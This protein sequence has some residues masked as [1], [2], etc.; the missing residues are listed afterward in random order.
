M[1]IADLRRVLAAVALL[2]AALALWFASSAHAGIDCDLNP[3]ARICN[4]DGD[5]GGDPGGGETG[6]AQPLAFTSS[7]RDEIGAG[8]F[9][10]TTTTVDRGA[11]TMNSTVHIWTTNW[12]WG[13]QG[14]AEF[15]LV[16]RG[17]TVLTHSQKLCYGVDGTAIGVPART[18]YVQWHLGSYPASL[19]DSVRIIHSKL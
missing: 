10:S 15:E 2:L 7:Q 4:P 14:C 18:D 16:S 9:M 5:P 13:F 6:P 17:G 19:V 12:F 11:L 1:T 8:E 3:T